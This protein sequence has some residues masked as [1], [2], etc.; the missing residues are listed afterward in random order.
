MRKLLLPFLLA[1][2]L[3]AG[4]QL[5]TYKVDIGQTM[6]DVM[7]VSDFYRYPSFQTSRVQFRD[8]Y[9][10]TAMM[11]LNFIEGR[12]QF[13]SPGGDTLV[14]EGL[15]Q[16]AHVAIGKDTF[17]F[18]GGALEQVGAW[19]GWG[20]LLQRQ[21]LMEEGVTRVGGYDS[22]EPSGAVEAVTKYNAANMVRSIAMRQRTTIVRQSKL[23]V[24]KDDATVPVLLDRKE[25]ESLFPGRK[26]A[27]RDYLRETKVDFRIPAQVL[28]LVNH[29]RSLP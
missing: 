20:R 3:T 6:D 16:L 2:C 1:F 7:S 27:I 25:F 21:Y 14:L 17:F 5:P 4:A 29:V 9:I 8:G 19:P 13:I 15:D 18:Y 12:L 23:Y 10:K 11:N 26:S 22:N 24:W 28:R